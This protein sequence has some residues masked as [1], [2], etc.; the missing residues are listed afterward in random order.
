MLFHD[1]A[2]TLS[3]VSCGK[4]EIGASADAEKSDMKKRHIILAGLIL[5]VGSFALQLKKRQYKSAVTGDI[6]DVVI[7]QVR[8]KRKPASLPSKN[9]VPTSQ[10]KGSSFSW[11]EKEQ[12]K[13]RNEFAQPLGDDEETIAPSIA[14]SD[15]N[16]YQSGSHGTSRS[17]ASSSNPSA[18]SSRTPG[19]PGKTGQPSSSFPSYVG[20]NQPT[21]TPT[22]PK[23]EDP[24]ETNSGSNTQDSVTPVCS[25]NISGGTFNGPVTVNLT[26]STASTIKYC[27]SE[28]ICCDPDSGSIYTGPIQIGQAS[29]NYCLSFSG[30]ALEGGLISQTSETFFQFDPN[31]PDI[32]VVQEKNY[33]Q[34]TQLDAPLKL[35][36]SDFGSN[37]HS[38]GIINLKTH[39][40]SPSGLNLSCQ[41]IVEDHATLSSPSTL[42]IFPET[43]VVAYS[44]STELNMSLAESSLIYGKNN[45]TSY[46]KSTLYAVPKYTCSQ[47]E[48]TLED[49]YYSQTLPIDV[50]AAADTSILMGGFDY[51]APIDS[52][53]SVYRGPASDVDPSSTQEIRTGLWSIF[54]DK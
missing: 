17:Y 36:S 4:I 15:D 42:N 43:S 10:M 11:T 23:N 8:T 39:D 40:P 44:P 6:E 49:F 41:D 14:G 53:P 35:R 27:I 19:T 9:I 32:M 21:P 30:A 47:T 1:G 20:V 13:E 34:T 12:A 52:T 50:L 46:L 38:V 45:L 3:A 48:L 24:K 54:F 29:K 33:V 22:V 28:N 18:S 25:S 37:H 51:L 26:C 31:V 2:G 7:K 5:L 16:F